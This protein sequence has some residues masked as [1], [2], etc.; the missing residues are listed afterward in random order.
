MEKAFPVDESTGTMTKDLIVNAQS[1]L[2][3]GYYLEKYFL[4]HQ[5]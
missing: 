3:T 5:V 2:K 4:V 1:T